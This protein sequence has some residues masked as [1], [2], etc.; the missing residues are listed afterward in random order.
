VSFPER[1]IQVSF[2]EGIILGQ[3]MKNVGNIVSYASLAKAMWGD[4]FPEAKDSIHVHIRHLREKLEEN[5][6]KPKLIINKPGIGYFLNM[7]S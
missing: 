5:P 4:N 2:T 3:L 6:S 1:E 7:P